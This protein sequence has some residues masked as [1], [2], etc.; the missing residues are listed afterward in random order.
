MVV[1]EFENSN[2]ARTTDNPLAG[3]VSYLYTLLDSGN[4]TAAVSCWDFDQRCGDVAEPSGSGASDWSAGERRFGP[5]R[6]RTTRSHSRR[7]YP[8]RA[9]VCP[10]FFLAVACLIP[11]SADLLSV[12]TCVG[13]HLGLPAPSAR[14][15]RLRSR[16]VRTGNGARPVA[17]RFRINGKTN[18]APG[19]PP[20]P[21]SYLWFGS[22]LNCDGRPAPF[23]YR[24]RPGVFGV[25]RPS[26][27]K[28]KTELFV[29]RVPIA[30][31]LPVCPCPKV[32][33]P[34][35]GTRGRRL[36]FSGSSYVLFFVFQFST[37]QEHTTKNFKYVLLS[38]SRRS[39]CPLRREYT[40]C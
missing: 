35:A 14:C 7:V 36:I 38:Q 27:V 20:P 30:R 11:V 3:A 19:R 2:F 22:R 29:R 5:P 21:P 18:G 10:S 12:S 28:A 17:R 15:G 9:T 13:S 23:H 4:R 37:P 31:A 32:K 26:V 34:A 8:S 40:N 39:S 25:G 24:Y 33:S 6:R 16:S 1:F